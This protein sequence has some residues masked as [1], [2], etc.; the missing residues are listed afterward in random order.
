MK[1]VIALVMSG[2]LVTIA[3]CGGGAPPAS[4]PPTPE[5]APAPKPAPAP[6][7]KPAP[8][9]APTALAYK[10][11]AVSNGGSI[12]GS[13][14]FAGDIPPVEKIAVTKNKDV[15]GDS[16]PAEKLIVS[17][18]KGLKNVVVS[19]VEI[20][21]GKKLPTETP[22]LD[23]KGGRFMP[24]VQAVVAGTTLEIINSDP[25][26][27]NTHTYLKGT[28]V[29]NLALPLEGQKLR[30][31]LKSAGRTI[32]S[33]EVKVLCDAHDWMSAYIM[34]VPHPY[35][36]V[37]DESGAFE[38]GDIPPGSY[39]LRAWHQELGVQTKQVTITAGGKSEVNFEF[40]Q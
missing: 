34:V 23:N 27:H 12:S 32:E 30:R 17:A 14:K 13:V 40:A 28:T 35:F 1:T 4:K 29:F 6:A 26:L 21:E 39:Q 9:P 2:L 18:D 3:A 33:G 36:A 20:A 25:V 11:I 22:T 8:A 15:F 31:A 10:E 24:H 19:I 16:L 7:P 5:P 37:S 38:I